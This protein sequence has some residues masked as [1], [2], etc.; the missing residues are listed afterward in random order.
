MLWLKLR[1]NAEMYAAIPAQ[2]R[3]PYFTEEAI[4]AIRDARLRETVLYAA[5]TV[6]FYRDWFRTEGIDPREIR[7]LADLARLPVVEKE[8]V[9]AEPQR[10]LSAS[11]L[12]NL[13]EPFVT[14]G[15]SG[16]RTTIY[17]DPRSLLA[18][19]AY[20]E[21]LRVVLAKFTGRAVGKREAWIGYRGSMTA[22]MWAFQR[23]WAIVPIRY[24]RL[25]ISLLDSFDDVISAVNDYRPSVIFGFGAYLEVL[26]RV[27]AERKL[28][29]HLP[30]LIVYGAEAMT[31]EG[32]SFIEERFGVPVLSDYGAVESFKIG[33]LCEERAAFHLHEDLCAVRIVDERGREVPAG[34]SGAMLISNL[35]NRGTVLL[36]YR[37]GDVASI[38]SSDCPCGRRLPLFATLGGRINDDLFVPDGRFIHFTAVWMVIKNYPAI[39]SHQLVQHESGRFELRLVTVDKA[40]FDSL[41]AETARTMEA[42]LGSGTIVEPTFYESILPGMGGKFRPVIAL[43]RAGG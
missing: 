8:L 41:A 7:T 17:H 32:R 37:L 33:F 1:W 18:N 13:A 38:S 12:G 15:S 43:P 26:F 22:D 25:F 20:G 34:G 16:L 21:R 14:S 10:F 24:D 3:L 4:S 35:V 9:R 19:L 29:L 42:V 31:Q 11:P 23:R 30:Q 39:L 2:R 28:Y 5:D 27:V 40:A 6:P 36:N